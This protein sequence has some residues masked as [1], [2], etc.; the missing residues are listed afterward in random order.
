MAG[1]DNKYPNSK[2][3]IL[4][5]AEKLFIDSDGYF[6]MN[7]NDVSGN[8]LDK[9]VQQ[10]AQQITIIN[11]AGVL[12]T[13]NLPTGYDLIIVS[14]AAAA[15]NASAWLCSETLA[16]GQKRLLLFRG[17][18][19]GKV[20]LST[21]GISVVGT[22]SGE[23]SSISITNSATSFAWI[24]LL[25]TDTSEWSIIGRP[26]DISGCVVEQGLA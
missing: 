10:R 21:S 20:F 2:V 26:S 1:P 9:F 18:S 4:Q 7:G 17:D 3:G 22:M 8:Q 24:Q 13:I 16:I 12:S 25:A 5:G 6:S 15:S 14:V 11:S 23:I 19:V